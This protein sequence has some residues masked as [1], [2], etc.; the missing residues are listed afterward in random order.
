MTIKLDDFNVGDE[1]TVTISGTVA[2]IN[3]DQ[4]Y[5]D[6][7]IVIS[8]SG[9]DDDE[10]YLSPDMKG[11]TVKVDDEWKEGDVIQHDGQNYIVWKPYST[12]HIIGRNEGGGRT[13]AQFKESYPK[14]RRV[15]R[16]SK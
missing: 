6:D 10:L 12:A 1:V 8:Y 4:P 13:V 9:D 7:A 14:A 11:V 16:A 15:L 3:T 5:S 2:D